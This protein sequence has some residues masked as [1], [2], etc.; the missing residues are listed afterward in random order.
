MKWYWLQFVA[1]VRGKFY[2]WPSMPWI[3]D[4]YTGVSCALKTWREA[5]DMYAEGW[6]PWSIQA[7][8]DGS[9]SR[10]F[11]VKERYPSPP[12]FGPSP[13]ER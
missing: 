7:A 8:W 6:I 9:P 4:G 12:W 1:W 13:E 11:I 5:R 3:P 10:L 2:R